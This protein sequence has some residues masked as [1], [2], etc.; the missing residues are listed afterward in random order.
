MKNKII[1]MLKVNVLTVFH[2]HW[3]NFADMKPLLFFIG[4][5]DQLDKFCPTVSRL[6]VF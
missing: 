5:T 3:C 1:Y 6:F 2:S 4:S